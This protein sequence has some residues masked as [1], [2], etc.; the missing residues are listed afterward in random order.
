MARNTFGGS[1]SDVAEDANGVR[2]PGVIGTVWDGPTSGAA[3]ITDL[4]DLD[5]APLSELQADERGCLPSF[6]G[7][8]G[9]EILWVDFGAGKVAL[10]SVTVGKRLG[11]HLNAADPHGSKAAALAEFNAQKGAANGIATLDAFGLVVDSQI[12]I[13]QLADWLNVKSRPYDALGNGVADDTAA[14]RAA[15]NA[16]GVGGVVY[17]PKGVYRIS[18]TLDLPRGVT[19]M[20]SHSN[21]MVGPGMADED[22]PCYIQALPS[23]TTGAMIQII[24][25]A[26]GTHPAINGEQRILNLMLDGS[27]VTT[28][29]LDGIYAKGNVQN[30]VM[31]DVCVRKMPNNGIITGANAKEEMPYSW[32]LHSVMV[33]NCK[34]NGIVFDKQTDLTMF[35]VQV[36]GCWATGI[37][38]INSANTILEACRAEWNGGHGFWITGAWG[39]WPGSGSMTMNSCSTDRNGFDGVRVDATGNGPFLI[40]A[41]QTR[42]DGRN[43]GPGGGGYAGLALLNQAPVVVTGLGCYVGTDDQ[44]TANTSPQYGVRIA[45]A[46]DVNILGA[47]LH[48][49]TAGVFQEG[50]NTRIKLTAYTTVAGNNFAEDRVQK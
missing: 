40:N 5:G 15:I 49:A 44:G 38:L 41:L 36:I 35:D 23:M 14:I 45:N 1:A 13:P 7:P 39:N 47:Y 50:T 20:G 22:F 3:Q 16:A 27:K 10:T 42:R 31:R 34:A 17:F 37:K 26:D 6:F 32:R 30:V 29:N 28:G 46:R 18:G 33:D 8:D 48:G 12:P 9:A 25:D 43:G 11:I 19:L 2:V 4:T 24:G 21:L